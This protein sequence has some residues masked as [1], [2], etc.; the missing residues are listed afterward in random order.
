VK[1]LQRQSATRVP[2]LVPLRYGRMLQSPC[3]FFRG[4]A[5]LMAQD[6]GQ[7][8]HTGLTAQLCGDAHALNFRL[9]ASPERRLVF[10]IN[11]FD[12]THPGPFEWDAKRLAASLAVA[13]RGNGFCAREREAVVR[14]AVAAY[15][16]RMREFAGM[17]VLDVWYARDE[18]EELRGLAEEDGAAVLQRADRAFA[19]ARTRD[20]LQAFAKLTRG[21]KH[22][23]RIAPDPPLV[24]PLA[25]LLSEAG[26]QDLDTGLR[27]LIASYG[28]SLPDE[29]R[30]LLRRFR[31]VDM[32]RK[33]VGVGSVG[34]RCW[35]ILLLGRDDDDP[36]F[37]QAKE[38]GESVLAPYTAPARFANQ[39]HR[40][41]AGQRLMQAAGDVFLGWQQVTGLDGRRRDFYV[42][43]LHDWKGIARTD[44]MSPETMRSFAR[45]CGR[46][47]AR[48]HARSGDPIAIAAYLG[49]TDTFDRALAEF[50]EAYADQNQRDHD[51]LAEAAEA[52]RVPV[53]EE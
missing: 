37:L 11:D 18:A 19:K 16:E 7:G 25:D 51:A 32:A 2:E 46:S 22:G 5:A 44:T 35:I 47:L 23:P 14:E 40:V 12:E 33:V 4:A 28:R 8:P 48:A 50:A 41:V 21:G 38:A 17:P 9:L 39:G 20:H 53:A 43:Q 26:P 29:R 34:T 1:V 36:L 30:E 24:T 31:V 6:L 13:G 15:R 52:G 42:R 27:A 3:R 10:D 49:G 45:A